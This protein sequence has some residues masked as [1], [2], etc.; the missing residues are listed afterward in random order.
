MI[1]YNFLGIIILALCDNLLT[2]YQFFILKLKGYFN[3]K[4]E[5]NPIARLLIGNN[6]NGFSF[7]RLFI[8]QFTLMYIF[9]LI[10]HNDLFYAG[11]VTGMF[12]MINM[13]HLMNIR[14]YKLNWDNS[15]YWKTLKN[16]KM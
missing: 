15:K 1:N 3:P 7:I 10:F 14:V 6:A 16:R 5:R 12:I 9:F 8:Y 2:H 4:M 13:Y 11:G